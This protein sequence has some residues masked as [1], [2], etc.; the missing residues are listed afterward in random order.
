MNADDVIKILD[1]CAG[2][3]FGAFLVLVFFAAL[4]SD[5]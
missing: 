5:K 2:L 3:L 1:H 4:G